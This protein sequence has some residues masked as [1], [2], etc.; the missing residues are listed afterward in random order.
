MPCYTPLNGY[1][2][3][4]TNLEI[5]DGVA[6]SNGKRSVVF[7][8]SEGFA[9][10]PISVPCGKCDGCRL[11]KAAQWACRAVHEFGCHD[12][13]IF[14]TL[15]FAPG[16]LPDPPVVAKRDVQLFLKRLRRRYSPPAVYDENG[17]NTTG[18]RYLACGE[19]G[20][21]TFR[22]HYHLLIFGWRPD[23]A[24]H[25]TTRPTGSVYHSDKI[26]KLW[27]VGSH[28]FGAVSPASAG[29]VARYT[30]KKIFE[31]GELGEEF[32]LQSRVPPLGVPWLEKHY[33]EIYPADRVVLGGK[34]YRPPVAYD[35]W[36]EARHPDLYR[37]VKASRKDFAVENVLD[38][39]SFRL[40][41]KEAVLKSRIQGLKRGL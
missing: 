37:A 41:V 3:R 8:R 16:Y 33:R 5:V 38:N 15:T 32:L 18:I 14:L 6:R 20:S 30:T 31:P 17:F 22:P 35:R 7:R 23:D 29:Y 13:S 4:R 1:R 21:L 27:K 36:L 10:Q 12:E 39:D 40:P 24:V 26:A 2:A 34:F 25:V 11:A 19:Y 28:E 9:D